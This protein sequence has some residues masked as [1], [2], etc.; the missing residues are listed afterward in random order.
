M[1]LVNNRLKVLMIAPTPYFADRGCH[2]RIYEEARALRA[3]GHDVRIVTYH[4][5]R[6]MEDIP[7]SR[8]VN[9]PWYK[10]LTAGPSWHK[11]YLD[12]LLF[13]K[14]WQVARDF[15]PDILHAHLHEGA[16]LGAFLKKILK[17]PMLFDY[18]GS[19][20]GEIVDHG[21]LKKGSLF[22]EIFTGLENFI[23]RHS[24]LIVVSSG[25]SEELLRKEWSVAESKLAKIIDAVDI[26]FFRP[27]DAAELKEKLSLPQDRP[28][29]VFT[30]VLNAYQGVDLLFEAISLLKKRKAGIHFLIV[31]FPEGPYRKQAVASGI[32]D[33]ITFTGKVPYAEMPSYLAVGD[34]AVSPKISTSEANQKLFNYMACSLPTVVFESKVNR[35]ILGDTGVYASFADPEN[36]A[37]E[38][39]GLCSDKARM[40]ELATKVR[41][42]A[43]RKHSW[44]SR[45]EDLER[46]YARLTRQS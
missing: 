20:T 19:L 33:M 29:V 23:H 35:E 24:D 26:E 44:A 39:E 34:V 14:A 41:D 40:I 28:I 38:L 32:D 7:T 16:F 2:V 21:F 6:D 22:Y 4:L 17:V 10:K 46:L 31:G 25:Q 1:R 12:L 8:V 13:F 45:A 42:E 37:E 5:G 3:I 9:I 18:Q 30:G 43:V 15:R 27:L 36:F 11:L